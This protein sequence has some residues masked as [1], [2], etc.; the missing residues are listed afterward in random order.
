M[1]VLSLRASKCATCMCYVFITKEKKRQLKLW[2][3]M[4]HCRTHDDYDDPTHVLDPFTT[5]P[6]LIIA[7]TDSFN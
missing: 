4:L 1:Y 5:D 2:A 3:R 7:V 6:Y